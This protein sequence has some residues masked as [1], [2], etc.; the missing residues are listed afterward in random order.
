[1]PNSRSKN[2]HK[3]FKCVDP[4]CPLRLKPTKKKL[5]HIRAD[6]FKIRIHRYCKDPIQ[7]D[8]RVCFPSLSPLLSEEAQENI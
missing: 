8:C 1:M 5:D 6:H 7:C 2:R 4:N 3:I